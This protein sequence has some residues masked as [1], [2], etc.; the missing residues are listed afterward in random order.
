M[1]WIAKTALD[2]IEENKDRPFFLK[3]ATTLPHQGVFQKWAHGPG[4]GSNS[5]KNWVTVDIRKTP[6]GYIDDMPQVQPA[7]E[8]VIDRVKKAGVFGAS[9]VM[10]WQDDSIGV[11]MKKLD[12][13]GL[14]EN[15]IVFL[16]S[17]H[18]SRGK[19]TIYERGVHAP[20]IV[21]W[22]GKIKPNQ[23]CEQIVANIDVAPT[24]CDILGIKDKTA[25]FDGVSFKEQLLDTKKVGRDWLAL[26]MGYARGV[27][28]KKYK[29]IALRYPKNIQDK[30]TDEN[31]KKYDW[32]GNAR[33]DY[34]PDFPKDAAGYLPNY[35]KF[36]GYYDYDQLY[37]LEKD[38]MEMVN[39]AGDEK[40]K[41]V[42][43]NMKKKLH[44]HLKS[45]GQVFGKI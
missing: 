28:T 5:W 36:P 23:V 31:R 22:K 29:Y 2:F 35:V 41:S 21:R 11:V 12:E 13:L 8:D 26:E 25:D 27:V 16:I 1:N 39:L 18:Q 19:W 15:T 33:I 40:Y 20:F 4:E 37:D 44:E 7:G 24:I 14:A 43:E 42:L 10:T 45:T 30:I 6:M 38:P 3:M 34:K 17:D 32:Q 9:A